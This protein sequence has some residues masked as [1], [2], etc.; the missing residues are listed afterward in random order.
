MC[1]SACPKKGEIPD[2]TAPQGSDFNKTANTCWGKTVKYE[3]LFKSGVCYPNVT[4][5]NN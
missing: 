5:D 1:V 4:A 2:E 3:V